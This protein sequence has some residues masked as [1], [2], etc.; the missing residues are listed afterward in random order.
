MGIGSLALHTST[1]CLTTN[2]TWSASGSFFGFQQIPQRDEPLLS[3]ESQRPLDEFAAVAFTISYEMDYFNVVQMLRQAGFPLFAAERGE[4][5]PLLI[6]GGP[7]VYTNPEPMAEIFDAFAM[8]EA[9]CRRC[10]MPFGKSTRTA[11]EAYQQLAQVD[12]RYVPALS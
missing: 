6:A 11:A 10:W 4:N 8:M 5:W 12:G 9:L 1:G 3:L 7:A 2:L